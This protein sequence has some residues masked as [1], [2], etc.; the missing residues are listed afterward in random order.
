MTAD[1]SANAKVKPF[2]AAVCIGRFQP[3]HLGHLDILQQALAL[4]PRCVVVIGSAQQARTPK[5]P[6]T[7]AER[8]DMIVQALAPPDRQRVQFLPMRDYYDEA[9]WAAAV[10]TGVAALL[11]PEVAAATNL[12]IASTSASTAASTAASTTAAT[13]A[14][15]TSTTPPVT[16]PTIA[17]VGHAKD[18]SSGYLKAFPDWALVPVARRLP[19]DGTPLRDALFGAPA[20]LLTAGLPGLVDLVP[21]ST[22]DFLRA[23]VTTAPHAMLLDEWRMLKTYREMWQA[24]PYPPIFVTADV[25]LLCAGQVLLVQRAHAPGRGC[26]A[27][28]GGFVEQLETTLQS[29]CRELREETQI[30]LSEAALLAS[31]RSSQVFDHPGRSLRGRTITH[32]HLFDLGARDQPAVQAADDAA[33]LCWQ[34]IDQLTA[35]E[36]QFF[37]DHFHI[38]DRFLGLLPD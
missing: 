29:A 1:I 24:A 6:F 27:L 14:A 17:L 33:A 8:A 20:D 19:I 34:P 12:T 16:A 30:E 32:A 36:D 28:P 4:A 13:T 3:L 37:D 11:A 26:W 21:T 15:A 38:L 9:R 5:N 35:M 25:V 31:H 18:A 10:R 22:L 7:W 23:W 2:D